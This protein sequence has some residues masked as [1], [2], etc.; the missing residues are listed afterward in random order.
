MEAAVGFSMF[1]F[2]LF[3]LFLLPAVIVLFSKR[4]S[5]WKK[6]G[7]FV[8]AL[9]FSYIGLILFLLITKKPSLEEIDS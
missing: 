5:G 3:I 4:S 8:I 9:W 7:W 6:V 2:V 1:G